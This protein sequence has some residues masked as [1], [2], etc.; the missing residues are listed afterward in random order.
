MF[1][2]G[3]GL[4]YLT[5]AIGRRP[6]SRMRSTIS[7]ARCSSTRSSARRSACSASSTARGADDPKATAKAAA[8]FN[9]AADLAPDDVTALRA[10]AMRPRA[11]G[12][13][14]P[15]LELFLRS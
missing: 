10:A 2:L 5:G 4:G 9:Y 8:K 7:S 3:R 11:A 13:W 12:K 6:T 14:E 1:M 15:A